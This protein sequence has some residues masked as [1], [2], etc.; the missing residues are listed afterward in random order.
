MH[1]HAVV[2]ME[3]V[4]L[5][6]YGHSI[7]VCIPKALRERLRLNKG[8]YVKVYEQNGKIIVEKIQL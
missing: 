1:S 8:D 7:Y 3:V 5:T 2:H 6:Q 4:T